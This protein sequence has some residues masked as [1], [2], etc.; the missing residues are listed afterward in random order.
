MSYADQGEEDE[1]PVDADE[2]LCQVVPPTEAARRLEHRTIAAREA[3]C[4]II[5]IVKPSSL[6]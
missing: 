2:K 3:D 6:C 1:D 5:I 4:I